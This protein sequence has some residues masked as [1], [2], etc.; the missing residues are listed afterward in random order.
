MRKCGDEGRDEA[1]GLSQ[2]GG[3][4]RG[5]LEAPERRA[6]RFLERTESARGDSAAG[7]ARGETLE[8]GPPNPDGRKPGCA[9]L[10]CPLRVR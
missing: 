5:R 8:T 4:R 7:A 6:A 2:L 3:G 1:D 9:G 10:R